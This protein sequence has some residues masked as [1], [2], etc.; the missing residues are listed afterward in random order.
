MS[1]PID[2]RA[3]WVLPAD[4]LAARREADPNA[5][6]AVLRTLT[7]RDKQPRIVDDDAPT[8]LQPVL[9]SEESAK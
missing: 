6:T 1:K 4:E 5:A 7:V 8:A 9:Q 3:T 2:P